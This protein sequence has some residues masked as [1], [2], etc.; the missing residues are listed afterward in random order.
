MSSGLPQRWSGATLDGM[1]KQPAI[2]IA[3]GIF[4]QVV[5]ALRQHFEVTDNQANEPWP[6]EEFVRRLQGK[7]GVL[8]TGGQRINAALLAQCPDLRICANMSVGYNNLDLKAMTEAG[9]LGTN[10][11]GV[12]T[13]TTADFGFAL[14]MATARRITEAEQFLRA[15]KWDQWSYDMFLGQDLHGSTL[16]IFGMGR[17]GQG[18]ARRAALGFGMEVIYHNRNRLP[19]ATE[20]AVGGAR[21]VGADELLQTAD[22]VMV[23]LPYTP[24]TRHMIGA[25]EIA[26]MKPTATLVNIGRGGVVDDAA[27]AAA[28][29]KGQIAAAGLDVFEHEPRLNP[30]LL[31]CRNIVMTP[32][33]ASAST[34]TRLA[35]TRLAADNLVAYLT[36]GEA[37]TPL[38]AEVMAL[39]QP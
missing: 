34:P 37:L 18:I 9:V 13:D 7:Q 11:P 15:G 1:T 6:T 19:E 36:R 30:A 39:H 24:E 33:I 23:V 14:L 12:L 10:A 25:A 27:L 35:M 17:I 3:R 8:T 16:G 32:H 26:R 2:L 29:Q 22:H 5:E 21:H 38:N 31:A 28:L 20:Q 4:P